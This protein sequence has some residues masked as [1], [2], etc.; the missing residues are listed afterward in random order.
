M[1]VNRYYKGSEYRPELYAPP[2]QFIGAALEQAQKQ[3]DTNYAAAQGLKNKYIQAR[4][5]D[6]ARANELQQQFESKIDSVASKYNGDYSQAGKELMALQNEMAKAYSPGGEAH[7]IQQN[8]MLTQD[9]I[10]REQERLAK[11][12]IQQQQL[13]SLNS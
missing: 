8:Y 3:Y 10:K 2:V 6:R 13:A 11:G 5:Q 1:G 7:A 4:A 9:S 12:E